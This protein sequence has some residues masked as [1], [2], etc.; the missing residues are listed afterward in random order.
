MCVSQ[1]WSMVGKFLLVLSLSFSLA[2]FGQVSGGGST[3]GAG[4]GSSGTTASGASVPGAGA[5][6]GIPTTQGT[7]GGVS[8]QAAQGP[9]SPPGASNGLPTV[10]QA[11]GGP[12]A[13]TG[14]NQENPAEQNTVPTNNGTFFGTGGTGGGVVT[15]PTATFASPAPTAG[16]SDAGVAGI[17]TSNP[18][19]TGVQSTL[20]SSTMVFTNVSPVNPHAMST[21]AVTSGRLI[22]DLGPSEFAGAANTGA[23]STASTASGPSVADIAAKFKAR[24]GTQNARTITNADVE[25]M[26]SSNANS[27]AATMA[28][29]MPSSALPQGSQGA[30][31]ASTAPQSNTSNTSMAQSSAAPTPS[32]TGSA[33]T[34]ST[35]T[36]QTSA[37][38]QNSQA[39]TTA[40]NSAGTSA[41]TPQ[42]NQGKA[43]SDQSSGRLPATSTILPLLG[44]LGLAS[45]GV[46]LWYRKSRK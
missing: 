37:Q 42:I 5:A 41:T 9:V 27:G 32:N 7:V 11:M 20:G 12:A 30:S 2:A 43:Q 44:L 4:S 1:G 22:N 15:T 33:Q 34:T 26:L 31:A 3:G 10:P 35:A 23:V 14:T 19:N 24:Q 38:P 6:A 25:R 36:S 28:S 13:T 45:G 46:G 21:T 17:S 16:I 8:G 18:V 39:G 40:G 29:N